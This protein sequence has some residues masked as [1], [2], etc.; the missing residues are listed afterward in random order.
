[1]RRLAF[2]VLVLVPALGLAGLAVASSSLREV[3]D[4]TIQFQ[5]VAAA[6]AAGYGLFEDAAGIACIEEPGRGGMGVHYVNLELVAGPEEAA[7]VDPLRPEAI[8]YA[9]GGGGALKLAALEYIMF[10]DAWEA[11]HGEGAPPPSLFG[12]DFVLTTAPNRYGIPAFYALHAWLF[13]G[14]PV[15]QFTPWNP[16]V[17][18]PDS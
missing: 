2:V 11:V 6:E 16:R 18:C 4:A 17:T 14:N 15:A 8:V 12:T 7:V 5:D 1:M 13:R 9:Q 3:R 10:V